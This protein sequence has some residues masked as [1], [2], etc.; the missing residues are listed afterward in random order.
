MTNNLLLQAL[1]AELAP[2]RQ[3]QIEFPEGTV[4]AFDVSYY[5]TALQKNMSRTCV[6]HFTATREWETILPCGGHRRY[7]TQQFI[8]EV[9]KS[10]TTGHIK[11]VSE[12]T[13]V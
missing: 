12:W 10:P 6:A 7:S 8:D 9:L 13:E 5:N 3:P 2:T 1:R 11:I 4:I